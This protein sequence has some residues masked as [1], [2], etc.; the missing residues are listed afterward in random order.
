[1]VLLGHGL[2]C[3]GQFDQ[4]AQRQ[5]VPVHLSSVHILNEHRFWQQRIHAIEHVNV[6]L[7]DDMRYLPDFGLF[8]NKGL[9]AFF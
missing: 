5:Y 4:H 2:H 3:L 6:L 7:V 8:R 9:V 1:M